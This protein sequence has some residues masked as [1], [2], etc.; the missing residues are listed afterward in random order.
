MIEMTDIATPP[1]ATAHLENEAEVIEMADTAT[2]PLASAHLKNEA[3]VIEKTDIAAPLL[4][5]SHLQNE[6]QV[7][8]TMVKMD[9]SHDEYLKQFTK[10]L[11]EAEVR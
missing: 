7:E 5:T 4:E 9:K 3:E 2:P 10:P 11:P 8:T 1:L 6:A